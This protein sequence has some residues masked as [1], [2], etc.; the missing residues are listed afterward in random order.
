MQFM[1][2]LLRFNF[3]VSEIEIERMK[4]YPVG[5]DGEIPNSVIRDKVTPIHDQRVL[6]GISGQ[7][8]SE[9]IQL[10]VD[11]KKRSNYKK[12]IRFSKR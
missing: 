1:F 7:L 6:R 4:K 9:T 2:N 11:K 3:L 10:N 5:P 12:K 8:K